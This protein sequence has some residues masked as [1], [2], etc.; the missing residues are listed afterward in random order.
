MRDDVYLFGRVY[1]VTAKAVRF[2]IS[3]FQDAGVPEAACGLNLWFPRRRCVLFKDSDGGVRLSISKAYLLAKVAE[4]GPV[5][6][7]VSRGDD[8]ETQSRVA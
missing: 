3:P 4:A 5:I 2:H 6:P 8:D 7:V 1:Q